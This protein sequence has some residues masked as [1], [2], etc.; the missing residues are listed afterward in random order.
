MLLTHYE[1]RLAQ[2][3]NKAKV[4][5]TVN[6]LKETLPLNYVLRED[7]IRGQAVLETKWTHSIKPLVTFIN[8]KVGKMMQQARTAGL[9][10][11]IISIL[12]KA[13]P[14]VIEVMLLDILRAI[15]TD[16]TATELRRELDYLSTASWWIWSSSPS[17]YGWPTLTR[18]VWTSPN[19]P[20]TASPASPDRTNTGRVD[21]GTPPSTIALLPDG[22]RHEFER[23]LAANAFGNYTGS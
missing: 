10:W 18:W 15:Y 14:H 4:G 20:S 2:V 6:G 12:N 16:T 9:R 21:D 13:R 17:A 23:R 8:W 19:T 5:K 11:Q 1:S 7:Y 22:V 3:Y